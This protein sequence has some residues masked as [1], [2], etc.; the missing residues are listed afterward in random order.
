M[1]SFSSMILIS[2]ILGPYII[3]K[4]YVTSIFSEIEK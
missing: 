3:S 4:A 1:Q 2:F